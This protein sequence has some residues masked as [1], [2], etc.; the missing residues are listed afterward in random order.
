MQK[1]QAIHD[2]TGSHQFLSQCVLAFLGAE[3]I[4]HL[5]LLKEQYNNRDCISS[6]EYDIK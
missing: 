2:Y 6:Q 4:V 3:H 1:Q 5:F